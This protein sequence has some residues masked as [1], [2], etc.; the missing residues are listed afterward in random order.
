MND[1]ALKDKLKDILPLLNEKQKRLFLAAEARSLGYGGISKIS[2][3]SGI[4]RPTISQ[5]LKELEN[6][7]L[8]DSDSIRQRG[9]GPRP[10]HRSNKKLIK[11]INMI[12]SDSTRGDP[13][14]PLKWTVKSTREIATELEKKNYSISYRSVYTILKDLGYSLQANEKSIAKTAHPDRDAQFK[15]INRKVKAFLKKLYPVISVDTKKKEYLGNR[16]NKGAEWRP[17]GNPRQVD[18]HDFPSV[19]DGVA[20]PYGIYDLGENSGWV[21]VGV[22]HDTSVFAVQSIMRWWQYMGRKMYHDTAEE[23]LICA[24]SGGSNGYNRRLWKFELQQIANKLD[25][26]ITVCHLPPGT[27]K[28]N[29]VEHRLFSQ[30][31][32]N[33]KG[34]PLTSHDVVVKLISNTKT[35]TGLNVKAKLDR[36]KYPLG[37]EVSND[38][39]DSIN[40]RQHKFH[41]E[42]N[43]TISPQV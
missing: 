5:G 39:F 37:Q 38:D 24:D 15:Y 10:I 28:W 9:G 23:L 36:R 35:R 14:S 17:K 42:W 11:L 20:I 22:D 33:W 16:L 7:G 4:S 25:L 21:N 41:G 40:I 18:D 3:L 19:K 30:I 8:L 29:K 2:R 26:K 13:M 1:E 6:D 34:Q 27:S 31:S 12:V 43:Y 32:M